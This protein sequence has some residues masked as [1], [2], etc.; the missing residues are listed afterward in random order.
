MNF[1]KLLLKSGLGTAAG[2]AI[3]SAITTMLIFG[4]L[5]LAS[6][7]INSLVAGLIFGLVYSIVHIRRAPTFASS[8]TTG[9]GFAIL[10]TVLSIVAGTSAGFSIA[11][12]VGIVVVGLVLGSGAF[13]GTRVGK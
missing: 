9:L 5:P 11:S 7:V 10:L 3:Y 4:V 1:L 13:V 12:V 8:A 6:I 2:I